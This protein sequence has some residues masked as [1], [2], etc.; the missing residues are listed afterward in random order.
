VDYCRPNS[1]AGNSFHSDLNL[2]LPPESSGPN[3]SGIIDV[4]AEPLDSGFPETNITPDINVMGTTAGLAEPV[5]GAPSRLVEQPAQV[6]GGLPVDACN[7]DLS[8]STPE[9]IVSAGASY[10]LIDLHATP[11]MGD[12]SLG[13][14]AVADGNAGEQTLLKELEEMGFKQID[15]N[16][17]VLRLNEYDLVQSVDDLCGFAEWDPLLS[18][19]QEMV[20]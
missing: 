1:A 20:S 7:D 18:E 13:A 19:L 2:N 4:N 11:S 5:V 15:L 12:A 17:E 8:Q 14:A 6:V 10:P 3:G 9:A 16:K